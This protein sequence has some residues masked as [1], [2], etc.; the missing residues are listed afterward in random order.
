MA[1]DVTASE[2]NRAALPLDFSESS[3]RNYAPLLE[4]IGERSVVLIGEASHGTH[5]FYRERATITRLLIEQKAFSA[6]AVE[7][8]WPDAYRV[9]RFVTGR[10]EGGSA[11]PGTDLDSDVGADMNARDALGDFVRFPTWMWR[12]MD[13]LAFVDWL[14]SWNRERAKGTA[15]RDETNRTGEI[16]FFGL[17]LYSMHASMRAVLKYLEQADPDGA[18]RARYRYACFDHYGEDTQAYGYAAAHGL[19]RS[20]EKEAVAQLVEIRARAAEVARRDGKFSADD[21]LSAE[22]NARLVQN[23]ERYYRAMFAGRAE[24]WNVRDTHMA[25]TLEWLRGA[26]A[27]G[28]SEA[29]RVREAGRK[30]VV[31]AHNSHLGDARATEMSAHGEVNLG[32]LARERFGEENVF[33]LGFTTHSGEVTAAS[34]WEAPAERKRVRPAL[35]GSYEAMFHRTGIPD[36]LLDLHD[37]R[38]A[39]ALSGPLLERAIGVIYLPQSERVSHYFHSQLPRQFDAVIH[40]DRTRALIPLDRISSWEAGETPDTY[41]FAV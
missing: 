32:Q 31:W 8:D 29:G 5:D 15:K 12:N 30:I 18:K 34:D 7:A 25:E 37:A 39:E 26:R 21:H 16:G 23:A 14:R 13:V 35:N 24:S 11:R 3:E 10:S 20:C 41:P 33:L 28:K 22:Q 38:V 27:G 4:W 6:V 19:S 36:F 2:I 17:D 9:H 40:M 1:I